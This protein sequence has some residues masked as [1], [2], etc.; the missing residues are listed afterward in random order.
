MLT[1]RNCCWRCFSHQPPSHC[2]QFS[3]EIKEADL[4]YPELNGNVRIQR[5]Q[6]KTHGNYTMDILQ[7]K[8]YV[9]YRCA[10]TKWGVWSVKSGTR[11]GVMIKEPTVPHSLTLAADIQARQSNMAKM[12]GYDPEMQKQEDA[13]LLELDEDP[14]RQ[15]KFT[16]YLLPF[17]LSNK[18][19]SPDSNDGKMKGTPMNYYRVAKAHKHANGTTEDLATTYYEK[20]WIATIEGTKKKHSRPVTQAETDELNEMFGG[21]K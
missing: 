19:Y 10:N 2:C 13:F 14:D 1:R 16:L 6:Q 12:R 5:L 18:D 9:D 17:G 21:M 11:T 15:T 7:I 3:L 4:D 20:T 8:A